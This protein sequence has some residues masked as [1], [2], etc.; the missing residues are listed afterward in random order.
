[1]LKDIFVAFWFFLPAGA[2]NVAPIFAAKIPLL[3]RFSA[4]IDNSRSFKGI[5]LLGANKTWRGL[6]AGIIAATIAFWLQQLLVGGFHWLG[7]L[8]AQIDYAHLPTLIV[9]SLFALGALGGDAIESFFKRQQGIPPGHSWFPFDQTDYIIGGAIA[10]A[11]FVVLSI[12]QYAWLFG[13]WLL[14]HLIASYSGWLMGLKD[15]PI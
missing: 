10:T 2:A 3:Q 11:P 9:G 15:K 5:R 8:T 1:M 7:D 4:P 6:C 14:I 12:W 13:I